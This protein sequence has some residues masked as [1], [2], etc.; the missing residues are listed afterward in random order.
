MEKPYHTAVQVGNVKDISVQRVAKQPG[1][2]GSLLTFPAITI[3]DLVQQAPRFLEMLTPE[4]VKALTATCTQLRQDF[5]S[6]VISIQ[7]TND[8]DTAVLCADKWPS[9]VMVVVSTTVAL[10]EGLCGDRLKSYLFD[11]GW[12]TIVRLQLEQLPDGP[13]NQRSGGLQSAVLIV[14]ASHQSS[15]DMHTRAHGSVLA[16][17][18]IRWEAKTQSMRL[19]LDSDSVC[20]DP[21]RHLHM[22]KWSCLESIICH[23]RC[24]NA[25]PVSCFWDDSSSDIHIIIMNMCSLGANMIQCLVTTCPHLYNLYFSACTIKAA[26]LACLNQARFSTRVVDPQLYSAGLVGC[27]VAEQ[28]SLA[29]TAIADSQCHKTECTGCHAS[30]SRVLIWSS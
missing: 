24:G 23:G 8:Q 19:F 14:R 25:L 6:R 7:I 13:T 29:S 15:Q 11:Q 22:G 4:G 2:Q 26:A 12:S 9:M 3:F 1:H 10:G 16:R 20:V 18:A 30:G 21:S 28:L 17:F 27:A 5:R